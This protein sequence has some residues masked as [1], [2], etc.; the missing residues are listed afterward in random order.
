MTPSCPKTRTTVVVPWP[1]R[2]TNEKATVVEFVAGESTL[3]PQ[4]SIQLNKSTV[5]A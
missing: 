2:V 3:K 5:T 4:I 1:S